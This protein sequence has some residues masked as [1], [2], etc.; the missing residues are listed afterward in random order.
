MSAHDSPDDQLRR[1]GDTSPTRTARPLPDR[2]GTTSARLPPR[3]DAPTLER[4]DVLS[5]VGQGG[6]GTVY[7]AYDPRL[8]RKVAVKLLRGASD[9]PRQ[10]A[11]LV[12][13]AKTLARLSHPNVV[14]VHDV[15]DV[16]GE[17]YIAMEF[18]QG[19]DLAQWQ[20]QQ[21]TWQQVRDVYL[22]AGEGLA[23]VHDAGLVY[24]DFKP[25]NVMRR[26]EDGVVK[27]LDFGLARTEVE[28]ITNLQARS[29]TETTSTGGT[30]GPTGPGAQTLTRPG[31]VVGTP[32]YMAPEQ[33]EGL[34]ADARSD[35]YSFAVSLSEALYGVRPRTRWHREL[36]TRAGA[37]PRESPEPPPHAPHVPAWVH[38][39]VQRGLASN[40]RDRF[41]SMRSLLRALR[42]DP[43]AQR[44]RLLAVAGVVSVA[45]TGVMLVAEPPTPCVPDNAVWSTG[46]QQA[47]QA[48]V[49]RA[50]GA[51][52]ADTWRL[53]EPRLDGRARELWTTRQEAC[54]RHQRGLVPEPHY[55][56]HVACLDRSEAALS[57]L[58]G[59]LGRAD[60]SAVANANR[61]A[62]QLPSP[63]SCTNVD[64]S[65]SDEPEPTD[66][67]L[68][69]RV[70]ELRIEL[71]RANTE[72]SVGLYDQAVARA[73]AVVQE[74][75]RLGYRPLHAEA[76]V[77]R[78]SAR[79]QL[80]QPQAAADL[81]EALWSS[82][83]IKQ[84]RV[85]AEAAAKRVF[86]HADPQGSPRDVTE[87]IALARS[88]V[89]GVGSAQWR[90]HWALSNN[91]G[92]VLAL[93]SQYREALAAYDEALSQIPPDD[94]AG[95]F[96]R[97][98]TL[99]NMV[100]AQQQI[101]RLELARVTGR[102]A[103]EDIEAVVGPA[104]PRA[105]QARVGLA[106]ADRFAGRYSDSRARLEG[107]VAQLPEGAEPPVA[108][109]FE[110]AVVAR[111]QGERD[112]ARMWIERGRA[113]REPPPAAMWLDAFAMEEAMAAAVEGD[114]SVLDRLVQRGVDLGIDRRAE[115][116]LALGRA[117]E[118]ERLLAPEIDT[119]DPTEHGER[120]A[121]LGR[122]L[123]AQRRWSEAKGQLRPLVESERFGE[124]MSAVDRA[125][126][127]LALATAQWGSGQPQQAS[128]R[129]GAAAQLLAGFDRDSLPV[130]ELES[131][132]ATLARPPEGASKNPRDA[133]YRP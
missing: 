42:R 6:M 97:A 48:G 103:I 101:G 120:T 81:D 85:A 20:R 122:A 23:A 78:G 19:Q 21:R 68:A 37:A 29:A 61:A 32:A 8:E 30:T 2:E 73:D 54:Q 77:Q 104:H 44:R 84:R 46:Q 127:L 63:S 59:L 7:A 16:E 121:L 115:V 15:W 96:E 70:A 9:D 109:V 94:D 106:R 34:P 90:T 92:I 67:P 17:L 95:R 117:A 28:G 126:A 49:H 76:L 110:A 24:R 112:A 102:R 83:A 87:A 105:L 26:D 18:V 99:M 123:V 111:Y 50:G 108:A 133:A 36:E 35:Q 53:L 47:V 65:L 86:V 75:A 1:Q 45:I 56:Q 88:L 60:A 98:T 114:G 80:G 72:E 113:I 4:Y 13:E 82:L 129:L 130:R 93:G 22:Q 132:R 64:A 3:V 71:A 128:A 62:L 69:T 14:T 38:R 79:M 107:L 100:F 43:A 52:A 125:R 118:A 33:L 11:R 131:A 57:E 55:A 25:A 119:D 51:T 89:E 74:A 91:V 116:L 5:F 40:P 12:R 10:R 27:L 124:G 66:P 58:V 31:T 41:P 39:V